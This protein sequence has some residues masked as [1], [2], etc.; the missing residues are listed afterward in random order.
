MSEDELCTSAAD[1]LRTVVGPA[2][3]SGPTKA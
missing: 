2:G 1:V 3:G